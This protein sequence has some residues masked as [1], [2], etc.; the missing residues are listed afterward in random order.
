MSNIYRVINEEHLN[1]ILTNNLFKIVLV[2]FTTKA[3]DATGSVKKCLINLAA[4]FKNSIFIYIDVDNY[5]RQGIINVD[6]LSTLIFFQKKIFYKIDNNDC[7]TIEKY[8][9]DSEQRTRNITHN[10]LFGEPVQQ[11]KYQPQLPINSQLSVKPQLLVNPQL[12]INPQLSIKPQLPIN[13]QL[14]VK[15]QNVQNNLSDIIN[16]LELVAKSKE[17]TERI[18]NS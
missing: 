9:F 2:S 18:L 4:S 6:S 12:P 17:E 16:K 15:P 13:P 8:F 10:A 7:E 11:P 1:E 3:A 14:P 5:I